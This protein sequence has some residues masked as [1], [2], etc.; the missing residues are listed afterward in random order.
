[1]THLV[2]GVR[3]RLP[4]VKRWY[5]VSDDTGLGPSWAS[6]YDKVVAATGERARPAWGRNGDQLL[7]IYTGGT[8]GL[9]KGVM[10]RQDDLF[11]VLGAG[12]N[13]LLGVPPASDAAELAGR[14]S[15]PGLSMLPA[16]PL[17]HGTGQFSTFIGLN[18]GGSIVLLQGA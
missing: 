17:M 1:V 15:G 8:T 13:A 2:E 6:S 10:W 9:P 14:I 7:L 3:A 5:V 4:N 16:C 11:N 12:G 18:M